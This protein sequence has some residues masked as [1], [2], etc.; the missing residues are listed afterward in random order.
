MKVAPGSA[1]RRCVIAA[2]RDSFV[3]AAPASLD[4]MPG[5][6]RGFLAAFCRLAGRSSV[7]S[8]VCAAAGPAVPD[9][10]GCACVLVCRCGLPLLRGLTGC[11]DASSAG[12]LVPMFAT[13]T[14]QAL[15]NSAG[16]KHEYK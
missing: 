2:A 10:S 6:R 16:A 3:Q 8:A 9:W 5:A 1:C 13:C 4:A 7:P 15:Q 14:E 12:R 11:S